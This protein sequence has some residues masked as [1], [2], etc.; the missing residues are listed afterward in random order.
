[1]EPKVTGVAETFLIPL[2]AKAVET[3]RPRGI[4]HDPKAVEIMNLIDYD[5]GKF[6]KGKMSQIGVSI[7]TMLLDRAVSAF[8]KKNPDAAIINIGAGLDTRLSRIDNGKIMWYDLDLPESIEVRRKFFT[9]SDRCKMIGKSVFDYTWIDEIKKDGRPILFVAEGLFMYFEESEIIDLFTKLKQRFHGSEMLFETLSRLASQ[10]TK[11]H[12]VVTTTSAVFKWGI[13]NADDIYA[14]NTGVEVLDEWNFFEHL[15][16]GQGN[17][18]MQLACK[19][20][21]TKNKMASRIFH[22]KF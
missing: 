5:F 2:W 4:I 16:K 18:L 13:D 15:Q 12:D 9:D 1:M 7:R 10:N 6:E 20:P 3:K 11:R 8:I 19:I 22:I 17:L 21:Y 14:L